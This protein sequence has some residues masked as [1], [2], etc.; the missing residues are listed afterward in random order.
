MAT[1]KEATADRDRAND[2][3]TLQRRMAWFSEKYDRG[4]PEH[5]A[6]FHADLLLLIQAIHRDAMRETH[7]LLVTALAAV[8]NPLYA[9]KRSHG[10]E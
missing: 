7:R 5:N 8:P 6:E 9:L 3:Y 1:L 4:A 2:E 10:E